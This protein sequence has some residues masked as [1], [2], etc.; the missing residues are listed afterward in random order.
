MRRLALC[1]LTLLA[2]AGCS[3]TPPVTGTAARA[4]ALAPSL[5]WRAVGKMDYE[6]RTPGLGQSYRYQSEAGWADVYVY[7]ANRTD[8]AEGTADAAFDAHFRQVRQEVEYMASQGAYQNLLLRGTQDE[9][10]GVQTFRHTWMNFSARGRDVESHIYLTARQGRLLKYRLS[11]ALPTPPGLEA[12]LHRFIA[13][14]MRELLPVAA[15]L[16][17][18]I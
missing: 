5:T 12:E 16:P 9:V 14:R 18:G 15:H 1:C 10:V 4:A 6:Q 8:W 2:L 17:D 11:F 3:T 7:S 13:D